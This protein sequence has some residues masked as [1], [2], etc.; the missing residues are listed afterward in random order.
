[1]S[2]PDSSEID[3]VR[4]AV[5]SLAEGEITDEDLARVGVTP[6]Q[7]DQLVD[8][9]M[10]LDAEEHHAQ[11]NAEVA[12]A[13]AAMSVQDAQVIIRRGEDIGDHLSGC[14]LSVEHCA[15]CMAEEADSAGYFWSTELPAARQRLAEAGVPAPPTSENAAR[16][17][18][19]QGQPVLGAGVASLL[20]G[21]V[22]LAQSAVTSRPVQEAVA[23]TGSNALS[24]RV[25]DA[26]AAAQA[27]ADRIDPALLDRIDGVLA[28]EA[29]ASLAQQVT[30]CGQA[31]DAADGAV[32]HSETSREDAE[33]AEQ[34]ARWQADDRAIEWGD[35]TAELW[36]QP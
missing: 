10:E 29:A 21:A 23:M 7:Y 11:R 25:E 5:A 16:Q 31:V 15:T 18:H 22:A 4:A 14:N 6:E 9:E 19:H 26:A 35:A 20:S 2:T 36:E 28:D 12:A 30:D 13:A 8:Y 3:Q 24:R 1:M 33:R 27:A 32:R 17:N 34:I